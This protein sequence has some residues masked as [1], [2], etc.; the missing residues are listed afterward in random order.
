[1][2]EVD[3]LRVQGEQVPEFVHQGVG[4][5]L[6]VVE[7]GVDRQHPAREVLADRL[8]EGRHVAIVGI[9]GAGPIEDHQVGDQ[10]ARIVR[11][12]AEL[13]AAE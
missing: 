11:V 8:D 4:E 7:A 6:A 2:G 3:L 1:M 5:R 9:S 12:G 10:G 13:G